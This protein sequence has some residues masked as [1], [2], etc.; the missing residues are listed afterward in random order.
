M[1]RVVSLWLPRFATDLRHRQARRQTH[2]RSGAPPAEPAPG[3]LVLVDS[4]GGRLELAAVDGA[5]AA[6]GLVPGL[7]LADARA[8]VPGLRSAAHDPAGDARALVRLAEWCGRY[9]PWC[10]PDA[11]GCE[12]GGGAGLLLDVTG[13]AHLFGPDETAGEAALLTDLAARLGRLGLSAR[14]ALAATPG[15][16]W[17]LARF[18][19]AAVLPAGADLRAA[20][21]P[22]PPAALRLPPA[23]CALSER[24]GLREIGALFDLP[25][26]SLAP[27]FGPLVA[28]RLAQALGAEAEPIAPLRPVAPH[29]VRHVFAE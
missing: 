26:A 28:R 27:R 12:A 22:L 21:A 17:A 3:P 15:A 7:P 16:A 18:G 25:P 29:R 20:L 13:C 5:A 14:G 24:L 2:R 11:S 10:A 1:R 23:T 6:E 9:T 8:L 19:R 4:V